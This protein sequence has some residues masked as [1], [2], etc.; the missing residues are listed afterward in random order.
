MSE[1]D[2]GLAILESYMGVTGPWTIIDMRY[3]IGPD[4][5]GII[6]PRYDN[7][8]RWY[9]RAELASDP[10]FRGRWLLEKRTDQILGVS[11]VAPWDSTGYESPD[12]TG[13]F[14]EGPPQNYLGLPGQW[15]GTPYDFVT[16]EGDSGNPGLPPEV[17]DCLAAI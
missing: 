12:W 11:A 9:I 7:V 5:P 17:T 1:Y 4:A 16:G 14:G 8:Q 10:A 6:E 2:E 13:F 15:S 3:F